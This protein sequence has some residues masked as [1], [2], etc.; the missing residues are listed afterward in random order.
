MSMYRLSSFVFKEKPHILQ[1]WGVMADGYRYGRT[2]GW[3][4]LTSRQS[5]VNLPYDLKSIFHLQKIE[6]K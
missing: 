3:M 1:K 6:G 2:G 4:V 5:P